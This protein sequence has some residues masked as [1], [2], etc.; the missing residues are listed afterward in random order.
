MREFMTM[1]QAQ[2]RREAASQLELSGA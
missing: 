2:S 1:L